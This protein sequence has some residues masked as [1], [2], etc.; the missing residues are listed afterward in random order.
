MQ[1]GERLEVGAD[2]MREAV[3][4]ARR[5]P[6]PAPAG[7]PGRAAAPPERGASRHPG[8]ETSPGT[9]P[10]PS[11]YAPPRAAAIDRSEL[12]G[13]RLALHEPHRVGSRLDPLLFDDAL[14]RGAYELLAST[15]DARAALDAADPPTR[16][17]LERV[18]VE[19]PFLGDDADAAVTSVVVQ[20]AEQA[21]RRRL[22]ALVR[23]GDDRASELKQRLDDVVTARSTRSWADADRAAQRLVAWV[24]VPTEEQS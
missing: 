3:T 23:A 8:Q 19:E 11:R 10:D 15:P 2:A 1:L 14:V 13:L 16:E 18:A 24:A 9:S 20:L 22:E 17:L 21:G 4:R 12:E 5:N 6:T 7:P